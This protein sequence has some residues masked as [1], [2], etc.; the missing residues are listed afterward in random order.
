MSRY[1]IQKDGAV[2]VVCETYKWVGKATSDVS[3]F[4]FDENQAKKVM[5]RM[6]KDNQFKGD[7]RALLENAQVVEG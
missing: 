3:S 6:L 5:Q 4:W 1:L 2:L 7:G